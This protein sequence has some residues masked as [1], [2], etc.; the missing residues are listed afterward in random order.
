MTVTVLEAL[1]KTIL[2]RSQIL[3]FKTVPS[4][5]IYDDL[6]NHHG[7]ARSQ[8]KNFSR[9][10]AGRPALA[11]KFLE[12]AE[13]YENYQAGVR[14]FAGLMDKDINLR[15]AAIETMLGAGA[16]GQAGVKIA[17]G[18]L[19]VWQNLARDLMLLDFNLPE[20]VQHEPFNQELLAIKDKI[21]IKS[22]LNLQ[23]VLRQAKA[24]LAANVN[25]RLAL[26]KVAVSF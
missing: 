19:D 10:A 23:S 24:Y 14:S 7:A 26:V 8:A 4:D 11:V 16:S 6:I 25:P 9:L 17:D 3:R 21:D 15:L 18:L 20:L 22:L 2:S 13:F 5:E 12:D 1:P